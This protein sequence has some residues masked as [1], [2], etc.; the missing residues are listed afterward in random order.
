MAG[1][2]DSAPNIG[3]EGGLFSLA[4]AA[5]AF[6][7]LWFPLMRQ[8]IIFPSPDMNKSLKS[9][10]IGRTIVSVIPAGW[11]L[12]GARKNEDG[13]VAYGFVSPAGKKIELFLMPADP[14]RPCYERTKFHNIAFRSSGGLSAAEEAFIRDRV[15]AVKDSEKENGFFDNMSLYFSSNFRLANLL[16]SATFK[17][18]LLIMFSVFIY[19]VAEASRR[20]LSSAFNMAGREKAEAGTGASSAE[21]YLPPLLFAAFTAVLLIGKL[22]A[23]NRRYFSFDDFF[24]SLPL[25]SGQRGYLTWIVAETGFPSIPYRA[26]YPLLFQAGSM[27]LLRG[28]AAVFTLLSVWSVYRLS[29]RHIRPAIAWIVPVAMFASGIYERSLGDLRGYSLFIFF[30]IYSVLLFDELFESRS[31][32]K[33]FLWLFSSV[34]AVAS[35]PLAI[36]VVSPQPLFYFFVIRKKIC[37]VE[38]RG[39]SFHVFFFILYMVFFAMMAYRTV[40][41]HAAAIVVA[42]TA[43]PLLSGYT[44]VFV[45]CAALF[46]A[47]AFAFRKDRRGAVMLSAMLGITAVCAVFAL[48]ILPKRDYYYLFVLPVAAVC[49]GMLAEAA[50]KKLEGVSGKSF[51]L[52]IVFAAT[53]GFFFV[54]FVWRGDFAELRSPSSESHLRKSMIEVQLLLDKENGED[55]PVL[56]YPQDR[57]S[58]FLIEKYDVSFFE[59]DRKRNR[60]FD[61]ETIELTSG[62]RVLKSGGYYSSGVPIK[63]PSAFGRPVFI[64]VFD[65]PP[66]VE[67][68]HFTDVYPWY[69]RCNGGGCRVISRKGNALVVYYATQEETSGKDSPGK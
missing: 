2:E 25:I 32:L 48:D 31:P 52:S 45:V 22:H 30:G 20:R 4:V 38:R 7:V 67:K 40:A 9:S 62:E 47:A 17:L 41:H 12:E 34:A 29:I 58:A 61:L 37:T 21:K 64:V 43:E 5:I 53:G 51:S 36:A 14:R 3:W 57:F 39:F 18:F 50:L 24:F 54:F 63:E 42:R 68:K 28:F 11:R 44:P 46:A 33:L 6:A 65:L 13:S 66:E 59:S 35:N 8:E 56:V 55:A 15:D 60:F 69:R 27:D 26:V 49:L 23:V 10:D 1:K 16:L 19:D